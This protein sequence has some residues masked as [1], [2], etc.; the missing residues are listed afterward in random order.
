M[1][2]NQDVGNN[3]NIVKSGF[4]TGHSEVSQMKTIIVLEILV[5]QT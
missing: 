3:I 5:L 1:Q 2:T 4:G